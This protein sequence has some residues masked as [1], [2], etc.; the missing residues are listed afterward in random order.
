MEKFNIYART[1]RTNIMKLMMFNILDT[2]DTKRCTTRMGII[3]L[4]RKDH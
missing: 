2:W 1:D 3:T 4:L